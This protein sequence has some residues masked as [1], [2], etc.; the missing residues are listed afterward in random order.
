MDNQVAT[1]PVLVLTD[2]QKKIMQE[3]GEN[4]K[5]MGAAIYT[6]ELKLQIWAQDIFKRLT[7]PTDSS[8]ISQYE[9]HLKLAKAD[10]EKLIASR[11]ELTSK[12]DGVTSRLMTSEKSLDE[13][14]KKFTNEIIKL[15]KDVEEKNKKDQAKRDEI[16]QIIEKVITYTAEAVSAKLREHVKLL[17]DSYKH[18]LDQVPPEKLPEFL[19]KVKTRRTIKTETIARPTMTVFNVS[20]E[21]LKA[22][23]DEHFKPQSPESLVE[24]F[25]T[26]LDKKFS[27][28]QLAW[29][30][31]AKAIEISNNDTQALL[32]GINQET[33]NAVLSAK[34][35]AASSDLSVEEGGVKELKKVYV[36][37]M[38]ETQQNAMYIITAFT[39]NLNKC[40]SHLRVG[41]WFN[42]TVKQMGATLEKIKTEDNNF[43]VTNIKFKEIDKL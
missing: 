33:Q 41:K 17:D 29:N 27:E 9:A 12:L 5:K 35:H 28:Y 16:K 39:A 34:M 30:N 15:K 18:A 2:E 14:I 40:L 20:Q 21:E 42:L 4:W 19:V 36:L 38:E 22:L 24:D 23:I 37:D 31:K 32:D 1:Q 7:L 10:L 3:K 43:S 13:P 26:E 8:K 11:K 25:Q 6:Q